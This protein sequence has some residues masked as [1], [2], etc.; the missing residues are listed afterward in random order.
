MQWSILKGRVFSTLHRHSTPFVP[1]FGAGNLTLAWT[2]G[3]AVGG[4]GVEEWRSGGV[5]EWGSGGVG[6]WGSGGVGE[7][8]SG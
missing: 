4:G 1:R 7:W 8:G 6:E 3:L 2:H 5:G